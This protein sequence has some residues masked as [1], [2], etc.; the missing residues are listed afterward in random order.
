MWWTEIQT[1]GQRIAAGETRI[2]PT[3]IV[4]AG[5]TLDDSGGA[6]VIGARTKI[7]AGA[8]V[9]GPIQIGADCMLGNNAVL[10]GP[11]ALGNSVRIGLATEIKNAVIRNRVSIGP[12]CYV[13]DSI[14]DP[15]AYLGAMVRTSNHRLDGRSVRV[16]HDGRDIDT[17]CEK[18][19]CWIGAKAA[20]GIQVVILPGRVIA[21]NS[22]FEPHMTISRNYPA[23]HYRLK[24]TIETVEAVG[25]RKVAS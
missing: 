25:D 3:A 6:I 20:L 16:R 14:I 17:G 18:L 12:M 7:C 15:E 22:I 4:E 13:A 2:H 5:A 9:R 23:G 11:I 24:Q 21:A 19:G 8:I 1:I 10:R